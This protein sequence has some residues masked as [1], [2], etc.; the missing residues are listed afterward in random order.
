MRRNAGLSNHPGR[1]IYTGCAAMLA[2]VVAGC[3]SSSKSGS[4]PSATTTGDA[5]TA[6]VVITAQDGCKPDKSSFPAGPLTFN[7]ENKDA[8]AVSEVEL[9]S[10]ER[11]VGEK[12]NLP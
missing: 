1:A 4:A 10:G 5:H 12:E 11:I 9:L 8:T 6:S 3:G 2:V 7:I